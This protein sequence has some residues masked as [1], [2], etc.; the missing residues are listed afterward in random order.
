[1]SATATAFRPHFWKQP[2]RFLRFA[3][4]EYPTYFWSLAIG[5][6]SPLVFLAVVPARRVGL[7]AQEEGERG[8]VLR[9]YPREFFFFF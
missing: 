4:H 8:K 5:F 1:M 3:S 6:A 2:L 7:L 9:S